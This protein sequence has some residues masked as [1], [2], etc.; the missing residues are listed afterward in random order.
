M[1]KISRTPENVFTCPA[2]SFI[3]NKKYVY[4]NISN[5]YVPKS[6]KKKA[7]DTPGY[8]GHDSVCIGVLKEPEK[9]KDCHELYANDTYRHMYLPKELP[10]PPLF[11][12]S[13]SVGLHEWIN[14]VMDQSGLLEDLVS[15]FKAE[16]TQL[17]LDLAEYMLSQESAVMQHFPA[18][19]RNHVIF[20]GDIFND[21]Y[22]GQFL[23]SS[24]TISKIKQFREL[25]AKRNLQDGPVML[26]YDSTNV[27]SQAKGVFIVQRGHAKD[28]PGLDQ[29]NTDYVVRQSDGLPLTYLHSPGSVNDIAQAK[30]MLKFIDQIKQLSDK[31]VTVCMVCDRGYISENNL[32]NMDGSDIDYLLML[33]SNLDIYKELVDAAIST[34]KSYRNELETGDSDEKYGITAECVLYKNG[35]TCSAHVI[36]SAELYRSGRSQIKERINK[37]REKLDS[38]LAQSEGKSFEEKELKWIPPYFKQ[39]LEDGEPKKVEKRKRGR[40]TGTI[41][42]EIK[43]VRLLGYEDDEELI[44]LEYQKAG[45]FVLISRKTMTAQEALDIYAK[46]DCVEKVFQALKSHLGMDKIGVT[47]EEA[48]H[49]KGL[50]WFVA[51]ILHALLFNG[52]EIL[53][54]SDRKRFTV[55]AMIDQLEAVKAD[56]NLRTM[57][58]ERRYKLT[59]QQ[60]QILGCW[61][62]DEEYIDEKILDIDLQM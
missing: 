52:T 62:I 48:M 61:A 59:K 35:P 43:T 31:T 21:T 9:G 6:E 50:I 49:G 30:E 28:D 16:D 27:N 37:E 46:R 24:L 40:G 17:I 44:N 34:L 19:A 47:T 10:E 12:D 25:W 22:L 41:T 57:K 58:Y 4:V 13:L 55:P 53:R 45:V 54:A 42:V 33:R 60:K 39:K 36:W 29:V 23:K 8:T 51:S 20:S 56:K 32:R 3:Q 18:W 26:C 5:R 2:G 7:T 11:A 15:V 38:F 14:V 1:G